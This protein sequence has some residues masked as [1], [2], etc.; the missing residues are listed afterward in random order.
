MQSL[1]QIKSVSFCFK[2]INSKDQDEGLQSDPY[3]HF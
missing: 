3:R 2:R 1:Q